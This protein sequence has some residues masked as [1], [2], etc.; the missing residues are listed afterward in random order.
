MI[1]PPRSVPIFGC[2]LNHDGT[3]VRVICGR[4]KYI[5]LQFWG[6]GESWISTDT[7]VYRHQTCTLKPRR[8]MR[9]YFCSFL[10]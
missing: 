10:C 8:L 4:T 5:N 6:G 7:Q 9:F 1:N 2:N 3:S